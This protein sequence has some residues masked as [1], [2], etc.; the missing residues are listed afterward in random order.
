MDDEMIFHWLKR[1]LEW[2]LP[3]F[4]QKFTFRCLRCTGGIYTLLHWIMAGNA[5][6][7]R[8]VVHIGA[9]VGL[10]TL[11]QLLFN[12]VEAIQNLEQFEDGSTH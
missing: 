7:W 5:L 11:I 6:E 8:L 4:V 10:N 3:Y 12:M 1:P 2:L 9:V